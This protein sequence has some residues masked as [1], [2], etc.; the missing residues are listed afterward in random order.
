MDFARDPQIQRYSDRSTFTLKE[1]AGG[2]T[3]VYIVMPS[4]D[5]FTAFNTWVRLLVERTIAV[6][7]IR[8]GKKHLIRKENRI[9]FMLDEFTQLGK[10]DGVDQGMQTCRHKGITLWLLFQDLSR[11]RLV[12]GNEVAE[13]FLGAAS[14][15][16]AFEITERETTKYLSDR[17]GKKVIYIANTSLS[18]SL[19][20]SDTMSSS[21]ART[22]SNSRSLADRRGSGNGGST[23]TSIT[24]PEWLIS[25]TTVAYSSNQ[26]YSQDTTVTTTSSE[27]SN[28]QAGKAQTRSHTRNLGLSY[29]GQIVPALEPTEIT[30]LTSRS[31]LQLI[32][33]YDGEVVITERADWLSLPQ[34]RE[35]VEGPVEAPQ[36]PEVPCIPLESENLFEKIDP[37]VNQLSD[38]SQ[39]INQLLSTFSRS[40]ALS[41]YPF[42][43]SHI[44]KLNSIENLIELCIVG[45]VE[46]K[47]REFRESPYFCW[48]CRLVDRLVD[49]I[50]IKSKQ[51]DFPHKW[52]MSSGSV[53]HLLTSD[54]IIAF[55]EFAKLVADQSLQGLTHNLTLEIL[56]LSESTSSLKCFI[57]N[58]RSSV[59]AIE[60]YPRQ[61][62]EYYHLRNFRPSASETNF[63]KTLAEIREL[64]SRIP[65]S[66]ILKLIDEANANPVDCP[67]RLINLFNGVDKIE[68]IL[69]DTQRLFQNERTRSDLLDHLIDECTRF[70]EGELQDDLECS[71]KELLR[72]KECLHDE[73]RQLYNNCKKY[74][75]WAFYNKTHLRDYLNQMLLKDLDESNQQDLLAQFT[76]GYRSFEGTSGLFFWFS[77]CSNRV[78]SVCDALVLLEQI[79][80][81]TTQCLFIDYLHLLYTASTLAEEIESKLTFFS[82][83]PIWERLREQEEAGPIKNVSTDIPAFI[84]NPGVS[85]SSVFLDCI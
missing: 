62:E 25:N 22:L 45:G 11:L 85:K 49:D 81:F 10:L 35:R 5:Y 9:L 3:T 7:P 33:F 43:G 18:E 46:N 72:I 79:L 55:D 23:S 48:F 56:R 13:S 70:L 77:A 42:D 59:S 52:R 20:S 65:R 12:Y 63:H 73:S 26:Q 28:Y 80:S 14:C 1:L 71:I 74:G 60:D 78:K 67:R 57:E 8:T 58:L 61:L 84:P 47:S 2:N 21:E 75:A 38:C 54:Y 41:E 50:Y 24:N 15:I 37:I 64:T 31:T 82:E 40:N 68:E 4:V 44:F 32:S 69:S 34:L 39:A 30:R 36:L 66:L 29:Q 19:G 17:T 16:Q 53:I 76:S 6:I 83:L 27:S 51:T